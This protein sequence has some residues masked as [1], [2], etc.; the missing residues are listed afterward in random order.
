MASPDYAL[1][2][3]DGCSR[4]I[5]KVDG[6]PGGFWVGVEYD[7]PLGKNDGSV[8]GKRYFQCSSSYGSFVR[9]DKVEMGDFPAIDEL[10]DLDEI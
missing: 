7:E 2:E 8:K 1:S 3:T 10:D 4:Y 9:P 5:G 6:L